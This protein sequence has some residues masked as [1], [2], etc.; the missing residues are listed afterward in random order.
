MKQRVDDHVI[1]HPCFLIECLFLAIA[2]RQA[3]WAIAFD[4]SP[5]SSN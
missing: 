1:I 4:L 3:R 2:D 5:K